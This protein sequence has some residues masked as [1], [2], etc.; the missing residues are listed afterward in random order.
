[1]NI[2]KRRRLVVFGCAASLTLLAL[3]IVLNLTP[4]YTAEAVV[5]LNTRKSQVVDLQAVLSGLQSDEAA[6][7]TEVEVVKSRALAQRVVDE[8]DLTSNQLLNPRLAPP[9]FWQ[10]INP[11]TKIRSVI[12]QLHPS[13]KA[14]DAQELVPDQQREDN[15][16]VVS[17]VMSTLDIFNDGRSYVLK[18][19][20]QAADPRLAA[21]IANAFA[22]D[23]LQSQLD[24][25]YEA[26]RRAIDW[27]NT[28]LTDLHK[29]VEKSDRAVQQYMAEH[30]LVGSRDQTVITQQ[31]SELNSQLTLATAD[32]TQKDRTSGKHKRWYARDRPK[33]WRRP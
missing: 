15:D 10:E 2:L 29:T 28:H 6:I 25:K 21:K 9:T 8:L 19:R 5:M 24:A 14:V 32:L 16:A 17:R 33:V 7:R 27:L 4:V 1:M 11:I 23:Y 12:Q 13:G 22:N 18:V 3:I 31:L 30:G 20:Y 26:T